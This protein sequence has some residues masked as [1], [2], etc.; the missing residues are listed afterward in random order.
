MGA[1]VGMVTGA[2][3]VGNLG[4]GKNGY[5]GNAELGGG[6]IEW[7]GKRKV[8]SGAGRE[9]SVTNADLPRPRNRKWKIKLEN[10]E[11]R[12]TEEN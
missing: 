10:D 5:S 1:D 4:R 8:G 3:V 7:N 12:Q 11:T 9:S 6:R 2:D